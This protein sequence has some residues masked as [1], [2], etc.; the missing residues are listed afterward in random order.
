MQE[1]RIT[2][3]EDTL[4]IGIVGA[5]AK[6]SWA[7]L[8]H[9]PAIAALPGIRLAA[10]A[11][12]SEASARAAADAFGVERAFGDP[13]AMIA[14]D[15]VDVVTIAVRVPAHHDLVMA[16]I[17]AGKVVYCE[18]PLGCN[19]TEAEAMADAARRA[20]VTTAIGLQGRY[21]PALRRAAE[22][23]AAGAIGRPLQA[24]VV[25]TSAG[26]GPVMPAAY[27]Y[28]NQAA[29][30]ADLSTITVAHT[31]DALETVLGRITEIDARGA[32]LFP[33]VQLVDTGK[34]SARQT[35]DQMAVL[36]RT[37]SGC[38]FVVD[39]N[40]GVAPERARFEFEVRGTDGWF[41]LSG[42]SIFGFQG[43]DLILTAS[44]GFEAPDT[45][46]I[47][48]DGPAP[49]INVG[50]V[51]ARLVHGIR[52]GVPTAVAG[53]DEALRIARLIERVGEASRSGRRLS[54]ATAHAEI[55]NLATS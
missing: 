55:A 8:S 32:V 45:P 37:H 23:I 20:G 24:R 30:G 13:F 47:G 15:A 48:R 22:L 9:V 11:T 7:G 21:N 12:R 44:T 43:G 18:S 46:A 34:T 31:L 38:E 50:E 29:S 53:F 42:G 27:D 5:D 26:F 14:G 25:S 6:A 4:R 35:P 28:F 3:R 2:H 51:Y 1:D 17:A 19:V 33:S 52:S 40:G 10:V 36:G 41:M 49:A 16:A 39:V 54:I